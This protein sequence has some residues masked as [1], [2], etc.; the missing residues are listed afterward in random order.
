MPFSSLLN[1]WAVALALGLPAPLAWAQ[2]PARPPPGADDYTLTLPAGPSMHRAG[3]GSVEFVGTATVLIRYQGFTILTDPN[4]LRRGERAH[5]GF[6]ISSARRTEPAFG[7]DALPPLDL[8]ILS[9]AHEDHFDRRVQEGLRRNVPVVTTPEASEWL[10]ELGFTQ[11]YPLKAW[12]SLTVRKGPALLRVTAMPGRHGPRPV[13][14]L[15]PDVMGAILDFTNSDAGA[16]YRIYISGDTLLVDGIADIPRRFPDIDLA[17]LH[18][19]GE[20]LLGLFRL[21]MDGADGARMLRMLSPRRA[22]PVHVDDYGMYKSPAA[23]FAE[24]VRQ[25]GM[26]DKVIYLRGGDIFSFSPQRR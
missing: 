20:R 18:L 7:L 1:R 10:G 25:A 9:H 19:G 15:L 23:D 26:Q 22:I 5:L 24:Q 14:A 4:F 16:A 8:V 11:R 3:S 21:T 12:D 6:G 13:A 17:L 2:A